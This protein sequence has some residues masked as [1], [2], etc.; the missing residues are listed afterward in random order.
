MD[1]IKNYRYKVWLKQADFDFSAAL[2][3]CDA[4]FYEWTTFQAEQSAEKALKALLAYLGVKPPKLHSLSIL[5]KMIHKIDKKCLLNI[6]LKSLQTFT[7]TSRYP[8]I[9]PGDNMTPHEIIELEDA[10]ESIEEC[11]KIIESVKIYING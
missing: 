6:K 10:Q 5:T 4:G 11:R 7:F 9:I 2:C 8:F 3:S 1:E